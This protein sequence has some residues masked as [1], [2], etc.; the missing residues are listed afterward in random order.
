MISDKDVSVCDEAEKIRDMLKKLDV[1]CAWLA[2]RMDN[3]YTRQWIWAVLFGGRHAPPRF[4]ILA[5][6]ALEQSNLVAMIRGA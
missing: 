4:F 6:K 1:D 2:R 3:V 5:N